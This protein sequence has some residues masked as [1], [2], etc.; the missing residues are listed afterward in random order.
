[1]GSKKFPATSVDLLAI[2][3]QDKKASEQTERKAFPSSGSWLAVRHH[4]GVFTCDI[5]PPNI[6]RGFQWFLVFLLVPSVSNQRVGTQIPAS[7]RVSRK[8]ET[9]S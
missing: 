9:V 6:Q 5:S 2:A 7:S 3:H 1:M 4:V 8:V